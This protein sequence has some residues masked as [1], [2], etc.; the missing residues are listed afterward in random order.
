LLLVWAVSC[1]SYETRL[2]GTVDIYGAGFDTFRVDELPAEL[3]L[4]VVLRLMLSEDEKGLLEAYVLGPDTAPLGDLQFTVEAE[5][6]PS[7]RQGFM[8][9]QTE[10]L[11]LTFLAETEGVYS[12]EL[13]VD[14]DPKHP[15]SPEHRHTFL[16][17]VREGLPEGY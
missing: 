13:Y 3:D 17:Y 11:H 12:V 4:E 7:H 9:S 16:F 10:V 5:P 15:R 6:G 1:D 14:H 8:V 2:D